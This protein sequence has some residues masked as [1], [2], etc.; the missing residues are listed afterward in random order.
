[1]AHTLEA[2]QH[3]RPISPIPVQ[4][5]Q[6]NLDS[7]Y[8][9]AT[10]RVH[11][12]RRGNLWNA[13]EIDTVYRCGLVALS[14]FGNNFEGKDIMVLTRVLRHNHWLLGEAHDRTWVKH[15]SAHHRV[16]L[17]LR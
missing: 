5:Q 2:Y 12:S 8:W 7:L 13:E 1:M 6:N 11:P 16:R 15:I 4:A 9:N 14:L 17:L 3:Q 10:L